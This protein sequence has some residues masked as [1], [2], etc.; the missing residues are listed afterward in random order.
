MSKPAFVW[1]APVWKDWLVPPVL[2]P[3]LLTVMIGVYALM[4][5]AE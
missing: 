4:R 3:L 2:F 1:K 5:T